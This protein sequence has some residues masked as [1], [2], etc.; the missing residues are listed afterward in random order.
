M[1]RAA[2]GSDY[3]LHRSFGAHSQT[4]VR[5]FTINQVLARRG[6]RQSI[7]RLR[8]G[9]RCFFVHGKEQANFVAFGAQFFRSGNLTRNNSLCVARASALNEFIVFARSDVRRHCVHVRRQHDA[10]RRPGG[11]DDIGPVRFNFLDLH[12]VIESI[13][14]LCERSSD[15]KLVAGH[16]RYVN[17]LAREFENIN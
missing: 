3:Y 1:R 17:Q 11:G 16:G 15:L 5:R 10:W 13:E 2:F 6:E 12:L 9:T 8:T 7:C 4:I 14:Q